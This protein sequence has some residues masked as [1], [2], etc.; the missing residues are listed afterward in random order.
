[1]KKIILIIIVLLPFLGIAQKDGKDTT[2]AVHL[3]VT[4]NAYINGN[5]YLGNGNDTLFFNNDTVT[6]FYNIDQYNFKK[7]GRGVASNLVN[8]DMQINTGVLSGYTQY[9]NTATGTAIT[10]GTLFGIDALGNSIIKN[11]ENDTINITVNG[12]QILRMQDGGT[13]STVIIGDAASDKSGYLGDTKL[14]GTPNALGIINKAASA[15][16]SGGHIY[17]HQDD[18]TVMLSNESMG[19]VTWRGA[20]NTSNAMA[21]G[22]QIKSISTATW[23]STSNH[24]AS[25]VFITH[26]NSGNTLE[27]MRIAS[28]KTLTHTTATSIFTCAFPPDSSSYGNTI[29]GQLMYSVTVRGTNGVQSETG[30]I[31]YNGTEYLGVIYSSGTTDVSTKSFS[32][33]TMTIVP[34]V[35]YAA[36]VWT[37]KIN[38]TSDLTTPAYKCTYISLLHNGGVVIQTP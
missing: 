2:H 12:Q 11:L 7:I 17:L 27:R 26:M 15:I 6:D 28:A 20:Y 5:S 33:G 36:G 23:S 34:T 25:L 37:V 1:M 29:S 35:E 22:S 3:R 10:D 24:P 38:A 32:T 30:T 16:G 21:T 8:Y 19:D 31:N 14:I 18:G 9:T 13:N 4:G